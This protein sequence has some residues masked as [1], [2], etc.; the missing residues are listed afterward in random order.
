MKD[1][2]DENITVT[3]IFA[4]L[5]GLLIYRATCSDWM[6]KANEQPAD[7][8]ASQLV[9]MGP[10]SVSGF[11]RVSKFR[12]ASK[13]FAEV[14]EVDGRERQRLVLELI[15]RDKPASSDT[16]SLFA[17]VDA[18]DRDLVR[19]IKHRNSLTGCVLT[20]GIQVS[21]NKLRKT[22]PNALPGR[23][24]YLHVGKSP[25][26]Y[27]PMDILLTVFA[28]IAGTITAWCWT[29]NSL[30]PVRSKSA[31]YASGKQWSIKPN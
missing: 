13:Y 17:V 4:A 9:V 29:R 15:P 8:R 10:P 20:H 27:A 11:T 16:Y 26:S 12:V 5:A 3:I 14:S 25:E 1:R 22:F 21:Q 19:S 2:L 7:L 6:S 18:R 30:R 24:L 28:F 31:T 23:T